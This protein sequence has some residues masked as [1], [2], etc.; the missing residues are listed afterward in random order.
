MPS[1]SRGKTKSVPKLNAKHL[2]LITIFVVLIIAVVL[3]LVFGGSG[4]SKKQ[5]VQNCGPYRNDRLVKI[6]GFTFKAEAPNNQAAFDKG[7][8]GRSCILPD[9]AMIFPFKSPGQYAFWM[10]GMK[11]PIDILWISSNHIII[12]EQVN[13]QPSSYPKKYANPTNLPAQ[14]VL[15]IKA[16]RTKELKIAPGAIAQ[17]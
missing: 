5:T 9:E 15:E 11:F 1:K 8:G 10:K 14:Y 13:L 7:L 6:N 4:S 3:A 12:A 16:N 2:P 17:F